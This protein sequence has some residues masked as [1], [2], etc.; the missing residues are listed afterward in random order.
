M[1]YGLWDQVRVDCGREFTLMLF[2]QQRLASYRTNT[3]R[4]PY[5]QTASTM[6]ELIITMIIIEISSIEP[7]C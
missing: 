3:Q 7:P 1:E 4:A 6:V 5:M 2:V